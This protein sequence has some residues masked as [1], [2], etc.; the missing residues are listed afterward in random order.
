M[1]FLVPRTIAGVVG[2]V[3]AGLDSGAELARA[4]CWRVAV[5]FRC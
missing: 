2:F 4:G 3:A 1:V 5:G